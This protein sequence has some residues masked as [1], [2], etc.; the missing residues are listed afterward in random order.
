MVY[1]LT[2]Y[3]CLVKKHI[4]L[5]TTV[6][7][8]LVEGDL[9]LASCFTRGVWCVGVLIEAITIFI[10][11]LL[12]DIFPVLAIC[13]SLP[14]IAPLNHGPG[15]SMMV[16]Y[17]SNFTLLNATYIGSTTPDKTRNYKQRGQSTILWSVGV[18]G[19]GC[20]HRPIVHWKKIYLK[21]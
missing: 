21:K 19:V 10:L 12:V 4:V 9:W 2:Y 3:L 16:N 8:W 14:W 15:L 1:I 5:A 11:R 13:S 18:R 20:T 7:G 6:G 17:I